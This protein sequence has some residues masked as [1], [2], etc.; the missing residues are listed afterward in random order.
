MQSGIGR[1]ILAYFFLLSFSLINLV[2]VELAWLPGFTTYSY[3][4]LEKNATYA[5]F[6]SCRVKPEHAVRKM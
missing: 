3:T 2:H 1:S 5:G 4:K 6:K